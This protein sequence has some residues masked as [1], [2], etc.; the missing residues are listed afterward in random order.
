MVLVDFDPGDVL[1][2]QIVR[3]HAVPASHQVHSL[4]IELADRR[5]I[6]AD[7]PGGRHGYSREFC[8]K[9]S[10]NPFRAILE[11]RCIVNERVGFLFD[12]IALDEG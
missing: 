9:F 4:D 3:H 2:G 7:S 8:Q 11:C 6:V 1:C 12:D 10:G 5:S